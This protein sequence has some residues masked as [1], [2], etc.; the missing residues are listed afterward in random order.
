M[1]NLM[2]V[3]LACAWP[4]PA[5]G[6]EQEWKEFVSKEGGFSI[7]FP[8]RTATG[9]GIVFWRENKGKPFWLLA[10]FEERTRSFKGKQ[11]ALGF[12]KGALAGILNNKKGKLLAEKSFEGDRRLGRDFSFQSPDDGFVR[13]QMILVENRLFVLYFYAEKEALLRSKDAERFFESF[14]VPKQRKVDKRTQLFP[15]GPPNK[16]SQLDR[17]RMSL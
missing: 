1:R 14:K 12:L 17:G 5:V 2:V 4:A 10:S 8:G 3:A 7:A 16:A 6:E 9:P 11:D 15:I 13:T